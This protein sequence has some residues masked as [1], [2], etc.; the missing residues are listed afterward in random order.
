[1]T[2]RSPLP[3]RSVAKP[4]L[5]RSRLSSTRPVTDTVRPVAVSGRRSPP[6]PRPDLGEACGCA[7]S[8]TGIGVDPLAPGAG[9]PCA[10]RTRTCSGSRPGRQRL[11]ERVRRR[12][13]ECAAQRPRALR[14]RSRAASSCAPRRAASGERRPGQEPLG[15]AGCRAD[16]RQVGGVLEAHVARLPDGQVLRVGAVERLQL[17]GAA[18]QQQ[19]AG[20]RAGRPDRRRSRRRARR[21]R[22]TSRSSARPARRRTQRAFSASEVTISSTSPLPAEGS[23]RI[24]SRE[25]PLRPHGTKLRNPRSCPSAS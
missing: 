22:G 11:C 18:G 24:R 23:R 1:M 14:R 9:R 10:R 4:S 25:S 17:P 20:A 8:V 13:D 21:P 3:S 12:R 5:P 2:C 6:G 19:S 7:G 15:A 16:A